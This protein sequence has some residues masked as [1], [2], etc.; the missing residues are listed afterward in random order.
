MRVN[1]TGSF[2]AAPAGFLIGCHSTN[3]SMLV[4]AP[5]P[6]S[7]VS[8]FYLLC[9]RRVLRAIPYFLWARIVAF[10]SDSA[11]CAATKRLLVFAATLLLPITFLLN[12]AF[13]QGRTIERNF[14]GNS[15]DAINVGIFTSMRDNCTPAPLPAIRL[16]V[17][18]L[19]GQIVVRRTRLLATNIRECLASELPAFV[20][21]YS[22]ATDY[23]GEDAFTLEIIGGKEQ[24]HLE[25]ITVTVTANS[26]QGI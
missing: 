5:V 18:P 14:I 1:P 6:N 22:S 10:R 20:A 26:A 19:H 21:Y 12:N 17:A 9:R 4:E 11:R 15:A 8:M 24:Q 13:G 7:H 3:G 25:H 23:V 16:I 2:D